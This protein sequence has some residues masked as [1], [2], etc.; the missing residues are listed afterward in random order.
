M[1]KMKSDIVLAL[2]IEEEFYEVMMA[3]FFLLFHRHS[4][5]KLVPK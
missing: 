5:H 4:Y 1:E 3:Y 2:N